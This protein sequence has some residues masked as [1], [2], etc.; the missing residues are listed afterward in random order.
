MRATPDIVSTDLEQQEHLPA[1]YQSFLHPERVWPRHAAR[2]TLTR[3]EEKRRV[4]GA[5]EH[6][7]DVSPSAARFLRVSHHE[8]FAKS[9][10]G[11]PPQLKHFEFPISH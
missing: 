6:L 8:Q 3:I 1:K 7:A 10:A 11:F 4:C 5:S 9:A 2:A